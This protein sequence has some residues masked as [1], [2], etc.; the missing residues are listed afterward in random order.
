MKPKYR[1]GDRVIARDLPH[2][3]DHYNGTPG[4][5]VNAL[6]HE[7][8]P[9]YQVRMPDSGIIVNVPEANLILA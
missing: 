3:F 2:E 9:L 4:T 1:V 8:Q 6:V 5:V 7:G